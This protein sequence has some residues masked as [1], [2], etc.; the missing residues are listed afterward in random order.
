MPGASP[1]Q[2]ASSNHRETAKPR[3]LASD[4]WTSLISI[5][6]VPYRPASHWARRVVQNAKHHRR[7]CEETS[8]IPISVIMSGRVRVGRQCLSQPRHW[9]C[10]HRRWATGYVSVAKVNSAVQVELAR[11]VLEL[12]ASGYFEHWRRKD[13]GKRKFMVATGSK[14]NLLIAESCWTETSRQRHTNQVWTSDITCIA[15]DE[16]QLYLTDALG[17]AWFRRRPPPG[18]IFHSDSKGTV[19]RSLWC[20]A[21]V[22]YS[23]ALSSS[24]FESPRLCR[25]LVATLP[26]LV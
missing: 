3:A 24:Q 9:A 7:P 21:G 5:N 17:L 1:T 10:R 22:A 4:F 13:R 23:A 16:G 14:R 11:E 19:R 2:E 8:C 12:S 20:Q 15:T 18:P 6:L 25:R 26:A